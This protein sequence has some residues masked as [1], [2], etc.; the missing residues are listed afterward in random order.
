MIIHRQ[1][2]FA[3]SFKNSIQQFED[4]FTAFVNSLPSVA[5]V[6]GISWS[7]TFEP[8]PLRLAAASNARGGNILGL[9]VPPEGVI[10][11]LGSFTFNLADDY[12]VT[13]NA[14]KKLLSDIIAAGKKNGVYE[15]WIDLNHAYHTQNPFQS[16]GSTNY[17]F[18][19]TTANKYDPTGVF[20]KLAPGG[21]KL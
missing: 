15:S 21:F 11:T 14:A 19:K 9:N 10:L 20:Q 4:V 2:T 3:T 12:A 18:L 17:E 7:L 16:Y 13:E 8:I 5:A 6:E 1:I